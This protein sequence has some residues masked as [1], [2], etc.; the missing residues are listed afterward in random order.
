MIFVKSLFRPRTKDRAAKILK[1]IYLPEKATVFKKVG[2]HYR[3]SHKLHKAK[4]YPHEKIVKF[5]KEVGFAVDL[6]KIITAIAPQSVK[7]VIFGFTPIDCRPSL[8]KIHFFQS[9]KEQTC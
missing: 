5:L 8:G 2:E 6:V 7:E 9:L 1:P 4:L 3:R